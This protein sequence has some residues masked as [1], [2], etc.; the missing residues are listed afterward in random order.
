[1]IDYETYRELHPE[2]AAF[3]DNTASTDLSAAEME[4]DDPPAGSFVYLLP[5]T[6]DAFAIQEKKWSK[7]LLPRKERP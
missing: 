5:H 1:M 6:I 3:Q 7:Q 2:A 4:K